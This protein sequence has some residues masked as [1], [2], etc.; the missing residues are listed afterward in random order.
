LVEPQTFRKGYHADVVVTVRPDAP[1]DVFTRAQ[2]DQFRDHLY[3]GLDDVTTVLEHF[4]SNRI[5]N[6]VEDVSRLDGWA[7]LEPG[8]V[9]VSVEYVGEV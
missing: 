8:M 5:F 4:A 3:E 6:G 1:R 9:T 7:D 2:T